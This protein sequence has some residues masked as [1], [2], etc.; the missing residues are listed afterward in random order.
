MVVGERRG[1]KGRKCRRKVIIIIS[2]IITASFVFTCN[3]V[4]FFQDFIECKYKYNVLVC[5][6]VKSDTFYHFRFKIF[7]VHHCE[8][9]HIDTI[10]VHTK[11]YNNVSTFSFLSGTIL[12]INVIFLVWIS[13]SQIV[14]RGP[15]V[16]HE[17][18]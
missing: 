11:L 9:K 6:G 2:P 1:W 10:N 17:Q 14:V 12:L 18:Y 7:F 8:Y 3:K 13:G 15:L 16:A 5:G 4:L